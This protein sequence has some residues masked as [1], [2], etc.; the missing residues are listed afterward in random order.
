MHIVIMVSCI[1]NSMQY[2]FWVGSC[3]HYIA[4][5]SLVNENPHVEFACPQRLIS[6]IYVRFFEGLFLGM[7]D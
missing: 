7:F 2:F 4:K 6:K 5:K 3:F 1:A